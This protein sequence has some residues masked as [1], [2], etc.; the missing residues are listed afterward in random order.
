MSS[1][2]GA[3]AAMASALALVLC[4]CTAGDDSSAE[5]PPATA[6]A[7]SA[8]P[9]ALDVLPAVGASES[10]AAELEVFLRTD[11]DGFDGISPP[12]DA[13]PCTYDVAVY[14]ADL[15]GGALDA[16]IGLSGDPACG[17]GAPAEFVRVRDS[18][19]VARERACSD[20]EDS[21]HSRLVGL[22]GDRSPARFTYDLSGRFV[23]AGSLS[24]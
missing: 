4:G 16:E 12:T 3:F 9:Q 17:G 24:G 13:E 15:A 14:G 1:P 19:V 21:E 20:C 10:V 8:T 22:Y 5:G 18:A 6:T 2:T 23:P 11:V 7:P